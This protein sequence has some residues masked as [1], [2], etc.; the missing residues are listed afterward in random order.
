MNRR[1]AVNI[2]ACVLLLPAS[3][4]FRFHCA[5][6][7]PARPQRTLG[8]TRAMG[9]FRFVS[10]QVSRFAQDAAGGAPTLYVATQDLPGDTFAGPNNGRRGIPTP[11]QAGQRHRMRIG[12]PRMVE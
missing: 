5:V 9:C 2:H 4:P 11:I 3:L 7:P 1:V 8:P 10:T 12:Y 6:R